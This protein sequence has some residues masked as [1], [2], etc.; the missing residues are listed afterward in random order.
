MATTLHPTAI[1]NRIS[2]IDQT[3][4][5]LPESIGAALAPRLTAERAGLQATLTEIQQVEAA[6]REREETAVAARL[7]ELNARVAEFQARHRDLS[8]GFAELMRMLGTAADNARRVLHEFSE[9]EGSAAQMG[10]AAPV[11]NLEV[12]TGVSVPSLQRV[13]L[14][15]GTLGHKAAEP[16][17]YRPVPEEPPKE[18]GSVWRLRNGW[19]RGQTR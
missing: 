19:W 14:A 12:L 15:A 2:Q 17:V 8:S 7:E 6:V 11:I 18:T 16:V 9:I 4:R 3:L 5:E 13:V 10:T 1:R